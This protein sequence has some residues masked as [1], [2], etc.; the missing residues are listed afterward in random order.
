[1][2]LSGA[3]PA[4]WTRAQVLAHLRQRLAGLDV[5]VFPLAGRDALAMGVAPGPAMGQVITQVRQ[6]WR[7]GGCKASAE[8]CRAELGRILGEQA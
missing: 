8:A 5:P 2:A 4:G 1:M 6:W 7:Q 3:K